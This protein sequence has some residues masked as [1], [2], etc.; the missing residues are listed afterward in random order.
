MTG[1]PARSATFR[2]QRSSL[3]PNVH[4]G[5]DMLD[6]LLI[7]ITMPVIGLTVC[8]GF[9]LC[10]PG[11]VLFIVPLIVVAVIAVAAGLAVAALAAPLLVTR[12]VVH[13]IARTHGARDGSADRRAGGRDEA[14]LVNA[15]GPG[16]AALR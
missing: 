11:L 13:R 10:V 16:V 2:P 9:L 4:T 8:P 3:G 6:E 7:Y 14:D 1:T 15:T 12:A 5:P